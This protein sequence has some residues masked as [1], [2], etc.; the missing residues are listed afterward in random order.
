[1][2]FF[3]KENPRK[4]NKHMTTY[5]IVG[6]GVVVFVVGIII[7]KCSEDYKRYYPPYLND[8]TSY[9]DYNF[10]KSK[11]NQ[12]EA[13]NYTLRQQFWYPRYYCPSPYC[14]SVKEFRETETQEIIDKLKTAI[15]P[16][17][18]LKKELNIE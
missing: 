15:K 1:V 7:G 11:N 2:V 4:R 16:L 10:L 5:L 17:E 8:Y 3:Q 12:L 13:E 18:Q 14:V 9:W 6:I